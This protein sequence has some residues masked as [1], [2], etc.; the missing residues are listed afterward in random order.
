[1]AKLNYT[2]RI[3]HSKKDLEMA[4]DT[5]QDKALIK[6]AFKMHD[7]QEHDGDKTD[8]TK[9]K[10]GGRVKKDKGTVRTFCGGGKTGKYK[11]GGLIKADE[12]TKKAAGKPSEQGP[13][14][15]KKGGKC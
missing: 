11:A 4:D 14:K 12:P 3:D 15:F 13:D 5:K 6:K 7:E 1:M 8:L 10:K 9:L 2:P